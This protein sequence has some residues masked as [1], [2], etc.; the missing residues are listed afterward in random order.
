MPLSRFEWPRCLFLFDGIHH[1][2]LLSSIM[3]LTF[4]LSVLFLSL[5]MSRRGSDFTLCRS[6]QSDSKLNIL[7]PHT[8]ISPYQTHSLNVLP[9]LHTCQNR[10]LLPRP[11][12]R[13]EFTV[14]LL[15]LLAGDVS[16]N[17]GPTHNL[18]AATVNARSMH[19]KGPVLS[20]LMVGKALDV[21]GIT[22][23]W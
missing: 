3:K 15:L 13:P 19:A 11:R 22:E 1:L 21:L 12:T 6:Q 20:D 23:T 18:R 5:S 17:P 14:Q 2:E 10:K 16:V 7:S 4:L 8:S 9:A